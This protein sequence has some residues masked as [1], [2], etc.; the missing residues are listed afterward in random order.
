MKES[1]GKALGK[2][3]RTST[4]VNPPR[5]RS[6]WQ[7]CRLPISYQQHK[8]ILSLFTAFVGQV[9]Q[10]IALIKFR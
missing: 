2:P 4:G 8:S 5:D 7:P 10:I 3:P 9:D 6:I 1:R